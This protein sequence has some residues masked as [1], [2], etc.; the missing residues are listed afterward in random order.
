MRTTEPACPEHSPVSR[1]R[2]QSQI[3]ELPARAATLRGPVGNIEVQSDF[4]AELLNLPE[5]LSRCTGVE[6]VQRGP[7]QNHVSCRHSVLL[8]QTGYFHRTL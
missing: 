4:V 6:P 8:L 2:W 5:S 1:N 7:G 3:R